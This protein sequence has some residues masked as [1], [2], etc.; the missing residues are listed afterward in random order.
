MVQYY[1]SLCAIIKNERYLEE[2][3]TYYKILG[4]EHFY[5]YD[6]QSNFPIKNRLDNPFY[7]DY[8]TFIDFYGEYQQLNAYNHCLKYY[9]E[10]TE[11][12]IVVDGDE[13]IVSKK[14]WTIRD[15]LNKYE[16]VAAIGINWVIFGSNYHDTRP[17]GYLLE[18]YTKCSSKQDEQLKCIIKPKRCI[19]F[20]T[21]HHPNVIN[22][23][24]FID[25]HRNVISWF[26]NNN[27]TIDIIQI[28][29]YRYK[30]KEDCIEK[31]KRGYNDPLT[32]G[33][34]PYIAEDLHLIDNDIE[35]KTIID[36]YLGHIKSFNIPKKDYY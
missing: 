18:N 16:D 15:F 24:E 6:N 34:V 2:F 23:N 33:S 1:L 29:H 17:D 9:G 8:I 35:D 12:L 13:F 22:P 10:E 7:S 32:I 30:S 4:V 11:W 25:P 26:R 21:V 20:I 19:E 36:R 3:I 27:H 5:I 14:Y 31:N 28:N